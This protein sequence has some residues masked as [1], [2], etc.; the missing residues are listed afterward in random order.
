MSEQEPNDAELLEGLKRIRVE[1]LVAEAASS[2]VTV[3]FVRTGMVP[4]ARDALDLQQ[5][6]VAIEG[7]AGLLRALEGAVPA[8]A[9]GELRAALA[10]LQMAYAQASEA[11]GAPP[12]APPDDTPDAPGSQGSQ[13]PPPRRGPGAG[14]PPPPPPRRPPPPRPKIWTPRGEV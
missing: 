12:A 14:G 4:E 8:E 11:S 3:G 7:V 1:Q 13:G 6:R 2:L 10:Q 5:A 9:L